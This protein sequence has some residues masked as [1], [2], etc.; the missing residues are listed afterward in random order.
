MR[1]T[2]KYPERQS[3]TSL[4]YWAH[5]KPFIATLLTVLTVVLTPWGS[6]VATSPELP[7]DQYSRGIVR[8]VTSGDLQKADGSTMI[9]GK[10]IVGVHLNGGDQPEQD[11]VVEETDPDTIK[12]FSLSVGDAVV[13]VNSTSVQAKESYAIVDTY[14]IPRLWMLSGI[15]FLVALLFGRI[16][17]ATSI[18]GL[19]LTGV[20]IIGYVVPQIMA[21]GNPLTVSIIASLI[22]TVP[23]LYLAHGLNA[24]TTVALVSTLITLAATAWIATRFVGW[25]HLSGNGSEDAFFLQGLGL[26]NLNLQGL[27]LAGIILGVV[28]ILDDITT[29]QSAVVEE[30]HQANPKLSVSELYRRGISV[31]RE[32]ITSLINT[33]FLAY[34]GV[35][36]PLFLLFRAGND[37]PLWLIVNSE[38]IAEEIV[39]TLVGSVCLVLAVPITT[40]LAAAWF[41]KKV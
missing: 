15:F 41:G 6:A 12:G 32:H 29:A 37:Q 16:R 7:A 10:R 35:S 36:L 13:V 14:R 9:G 21:G 25:A 17:G 3:P 20:V 31:G 4:I 28:G 22:I 40:L 1:Y 18:L 34:A 26:N 27:L 39:R 2:T 5:M 11:V 19:V 38:P 8:S 23:S 24:R 30:L 33:L